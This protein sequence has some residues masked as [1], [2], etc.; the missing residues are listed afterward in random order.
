M[1]NEEMELIPGLINVSLVQDLISLHKET[2][3]MKLDKID[4]FMV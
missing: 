4:G 3:T 1:K 2:P